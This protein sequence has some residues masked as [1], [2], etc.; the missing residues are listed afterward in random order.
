L[1]CSCKRNLIPINGAGASGNKSPDITFRAWSQACQSKSEGRSHAFIGGKY[2]ICN[3]GAGFVLRHIPRL[4]FGTTDPEIT[5]PLMAVVDVISYTAEVCMLSGCC[6]APTQV[7]LPELE[8]E[9]ILAEAKSTRHT[10][11]AN[12]LFFITFLF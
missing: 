1:G 5:Y 4:A 7:L 12:D 6:S 10:K 8:A 3:L 11:K 9:R 2:Q